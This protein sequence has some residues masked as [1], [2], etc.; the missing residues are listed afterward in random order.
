MTDPEGELNALDGLESLVDKSLLRQTEEADGEPRFGMLETIREYG[1]ERL[2]DAGESAEVRACHAE[3]YLSLAEQAEPKL[4]GPEQATWLERLEAEHDNLRTALSWCEEASEAETGLRLATALRRFW[5]VRG[6]LSEG[7]NSLERLLASSRD[8]APAVRAKSLDAT[9][10]LAWEQGE[11][12][13]ANCLLEAALALHRE[14]E[15]T[16]GIVRSLVQLGLVATDLGEFEEAERRYEESLA[17]DQKL[18]DTRGM[19]IQFLNLG[20]LAFLQ[21][22][23]DRAVDLYKQSLELSRGLGDEQLIACALVN[24]AEAREQ[25]G[26]LKRATSLYHEG[27]ALFRRLGDKPRAA[28]ALA[29]LGRVAY[30]QG[31]IARSRTFL[32]EAVVLN[33]EMG[34]TAAAIG[35]LETLAGVAAADGDAARAA[36]LFGSAEALR[37]VI[38]VPIS[39]VARTRLDQDTATVRA[40]LDAETWATNRAA[41]HSLSLDEAVAEATGVVISSIGA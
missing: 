5:W 19:S 21:G 34:D 36:R 23:L 27:L 1:L 2:S 6:Y 16:E 20:M 11:C 8:V 31:D 28:F 41:G 15:D 33:Q 35:C 18:N 39:A 25:Q 17:L 7:R 4:T 40:R 12:R 22:G 30:A 26:S 13:R 38:D 9:G 10:A 24:V 14:L 3:H 29:G 37:E 32:S